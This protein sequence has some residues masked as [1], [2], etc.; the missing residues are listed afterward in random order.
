MAF[1]AETQSFGSSI[2]VVELGTGGKAVKFGGENVFPFYTFD[3]AIENKPLVG[4]ELTDTGIDET[5][6]EY[7]KFYD[8]ASSLADQAKKAA[9]AEGADF[10]SIRFEGADPNG[11][12]NRSSEDCAAMAKEV[13]DAVDLPIVICGC[14]NG[15]KDS[16]LLDKIAA[17]VP[18]KNMLFLSSK[19]ENYK[20]VGASVGLAYK[21]KVGAESAVDINLAKQLN[22]LLKQLGVNGADIVM[23]VGSAA[24]G[25][26]FEYVISTMDRIKAAAL[27][28][29]DGD[30]QVPIITP[31]AAQ[32]YGVKESIATEE[33]APE[34]GSRED[35]AIQM[36]IQTAVAC[37]VSGSNAVILKHPV[38]VAEVSKLVKELV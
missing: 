8:G 4:I 9:E 13:A 22:V 11:D 26:G 1:K 36:E 5:L 33:D 7:A 6:S 29:G 2:G 10:I 21:Q 18:D 14:G 31:V 25:Y 12:I 28:Q 35:R 24:A 37:L 38:A 15:E 19:E 34:W 30:L 27:G 23:N 17:A 32:T 16:E 3:N 20:T